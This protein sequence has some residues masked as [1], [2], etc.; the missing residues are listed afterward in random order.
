MGD[1][2]IQD[3]MGIIMLAGWFSMFLLSLCDNVVFVNTVRDWGVFEDCGAYKRLEAT[4]A[5]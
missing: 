1:L 5:I 4:K 3:W 2:R